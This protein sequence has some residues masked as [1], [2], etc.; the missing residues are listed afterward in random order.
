MEDQVDEPGVLM[1]NQAL[2]ICNAYS[3]LWWRLKRKFILHEDI[4]HRMEVIEQ[5]FECKILHGV[6][7]GRFKE[8][9]ARMVIERSER[10]RTL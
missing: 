3:K 6:L 7:V 9:A 5:Q 4:I 10:V 1:L 8:K 2:V